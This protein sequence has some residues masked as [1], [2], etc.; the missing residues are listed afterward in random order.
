MINLKS[1]VEFTGD[2]EKQIDE[3]VAAHPEMSGTELWTNAPK[4]IKHKINEFYTKQQNARCVY[5]ECLL[6]PGD[7]PVEHLAAKSK[8][9][10]YVF[11]PCN[12]SVSCTSCNSPTIKGKRETVIKSDISS[13]YSAQRFSI[14]HPH[15]DDPKVHIFFIDDDEVHVDQTRCTKKG[16]ETVKFFEW[17]ELWAIPVLESI[18]LSKS[19]D[20]NIA[21][22]IER[23]ITYK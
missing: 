19:C 7:D 3:F 16:W 13:A 18:K 21:E 5:C 20:K 4:N 17:N 2:E 23:I 12:L 11:E 8:Y 1:A 6:K 9:R 14:V 22:L 15:F 10:E